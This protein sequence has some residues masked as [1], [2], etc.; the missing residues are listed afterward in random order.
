M[1]RLKS[2]RPVLSIIVI[3][4]L[5]IGGWYFATQSLSIA[6]PQAYADWKGKIQSAVDDYQNNNDGVFP[7]VGEGV[8]ITVDSEAQHIIDICTLLDAK[9]ILLP[10]DN[11]ILIPGDD[12]D[13]CNGGNC[14]CYDSA[15]YVW[16]VDA[17]GTVHSTC[18]GDKCD[19]ENADG[20]Q[21]VWP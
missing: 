6:Y 15:H 11:C 21:G 1:K 12:N 14:S 2:W 17:D 10:P 20:Y 8:T 4:G 18:I 7:V 16:T 19:A 5:V 9:L 13:N 3:I